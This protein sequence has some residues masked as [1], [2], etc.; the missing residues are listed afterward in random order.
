MREHIDLRGDEQRACLHPGLQDRR[1]GDGGADGADGDGRVPAVVPGRRRQGQLPPDHAAAVLHGGV[2]AVPPGQ[3]ARVHH[4]AARREEA[5]GDLQRG[6]LR[7]DAPRGAALR[8]PEGDIDGGERGA[9]RH[10][11]PRGGRRT[12]G[13]D[14]AVHLRQ[15]RA[16]GE[17]RVGAVE[18][19]ALR[20]VEGAL[21]AGR[22]RAAR[23]SGG[24]SDRGFVLL[25]RAAEWLVA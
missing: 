14:G 5:E 6:E 17:G 11:V 19:H 24:E 13:A 18:R 25:R 2:P 9:G 7:A 10:E 23:A 1:Q 20:G 16:A 8:D 22:V 4:A 21:S 15:R 3:V 12:P